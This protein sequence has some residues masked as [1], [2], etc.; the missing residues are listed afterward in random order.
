M[1]QNFISRKSLL[2]MITLS[3]LSTT[4]IAADNNNISSTGGLKFGSE[5]SPYWFQVGGA[6]KFDQRAF[7]GNTI[8]K[9]KE[10]HSG[11][12]LRQFEL[13]FNGGLGQDISYTLATN[14]E[15]KDSKIKLDDAYLTYKIADN[16]TISAGQVLPGYTM[17]AAASS[18]WLPF[19]EKSMASALGTDLGLGLNLSKWNHDYTFTVAAMQPRQ[20]REDRSLNAAGTE[21]DPLKRSDRW[22]TNTRFAYRPIYNGNQILQLGASGYF[23]DDHSAATRFKTHGEATNK[24][25]IAAIDTGYIMAKNHKAIALEIAGQNGPWYADAEYQRVMV[26]RPGSDPKLQFHGYHVEVAYV[27]TGEARTFKEYNGTFG[28]V[29]PSCPKGAWEVAARY[30]MLNLNYK[31]LIHGGRANNA[32]IGLNY[33]LNNNIKIAGEYIRSIQH[34][35][36]ENVVLNSNKKFG[37]LSQTGK[38]KLNIIGLRLQ[39]VF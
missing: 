32:G 5:D 27:L 18:K 30:S 15:A 25:N 17:Q 24:H 11:A 37:Q 21:T 23:Q 34:S 36:T 22:A 2:A 26:T 28:Q 9:G 20:D 1:T 31:D 29:K 38:R 6:L 7:M 10:F 12:N 16:F 39:A 14:Y 33:Y 3:A 35:S 4:A 19:F 8:S 13:D